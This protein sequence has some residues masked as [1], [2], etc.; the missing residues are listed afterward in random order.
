MI[1]VEIENT[2]LKFALTIPT[3]APITV[4]NN[5]IEILLVFIGKAIK[6]LSK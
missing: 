1:S 5:A 4:A 3:G 6:D 2:R